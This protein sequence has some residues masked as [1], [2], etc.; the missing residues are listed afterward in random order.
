MT[1]A[2]KIPV[3]DKGY[4]QLRCSAP[5]GQ[6]LE[7]IRSEMYRGSWHPNL[8]EISSVF[9]NVKCPLFLLVPLLSGG[10][11]AMAV[12]GKFTEA[13]IP[14]VD[15]IRSGSN[16]S[17]RDIQH[18]MQSTID[19]LMLNQE[20]YAKDGCNSF[21]ASITTPVASYW[22]GI[23]HGSLRDW[24]RFCAT[25]GLHPLVKEYQRAVYNALSIDFKNLEEINRQVK[26]DGT[27]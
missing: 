18:S 23:L 14:S 4:V 13:Y 19:S 25:P 27:R 17:D 16:S 21:L 2:G 10:I 3:L 26:L 7:K 15:T 9:L 24:L 12:P 22:T 6:E 5:D 1:D 8:A 11:R 20:G